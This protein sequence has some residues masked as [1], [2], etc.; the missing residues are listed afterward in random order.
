LLDA[1]ILSFLVRGQDTIVQNLQNTPPEWL[2]I[3]TV[4]LMEIEYGLQ[5]KPEKRHHIEKILLP[6]ITQTNVVPYSLE[7][8]R[9]TA[10]A[11]AS[12]AGQGT[13][14]GPYDILLAGVALSRGLTVVTGNVK[15]FRRIPGLVV[16]DW[17]EALGTTDRKIGASPQI[18]LWGEPIRARSD[19]EEG[20][21]P[22]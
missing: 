8:A 17:S 13:P 15:E 19:R 21:E 1:D 7:D 10:M 5:R 18:Y 4:T 9:T 22:C 12:L 3:S 16:E 11:R 20:I 14:I 2:A 6:F